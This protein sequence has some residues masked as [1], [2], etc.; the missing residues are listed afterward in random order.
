[1]V[2]RVVVVTASFLGTFALATDANANIFRRHRFCPPSHE[3]PCDN[4]QTKKYTVCVPYAEQRTRTSTI[5]ELNAE[6][7]N[8]KTRVDVLENTI[9]GLSPKSK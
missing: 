9:E 6:I 1:M 7:Q 3:T 8:L 5:D 2:H 4:C